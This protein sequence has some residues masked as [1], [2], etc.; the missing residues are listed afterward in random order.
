MKVV[1]ADVHLVDVVNGR[2][3]RRLQSSSNSSPPAQLK[4]SHR[5]TT[6]TTTTP[7][8]PRHPRLSHPRYGD[9]SSLHIGR[10]SSNVETR[11]TSKA[12]VTALQSRRVHSCE[13]DSSPTLTLAAERL[14]QL[15]R[16]R[17][18]RATSRTKPSVVCLPPPPERPTSDK[19]P[20]YN[21]T[22]SFEEVDERLLLLEAFH[23]DRCSNSIPAVGPGQRITANVST[24]SAGSNSSGSV[25]KNVVSAQYRKLWD[26]RATLEESED[27][28]DDCQSES[29]TSAKQLDGVGETTHRTRER[30]TNAAPSFLPLPSELR[31]QTYQ[32]LAVERRLRQPVAASSSGPPRASVDSVEAPETDGDA[33]D[34]SRYDFTT[35]SFESST[36][37]TTTT[38]DNNTD[39]GDGRVRPSSSMT[40]PRLSKLPTAQTRHNTGSQE[41]KGPDVLDVNHA[42]QVPATFIDTPV[43]SSSVRRSYSDVSDFVESQATR[44]EFRATQVPGVAA[45][46]RTA[47]RKR[48][49][50]RMSVQRLAV[51][52]DDVHSSTDQP[53]GDSV[54]SGGLASPGY[55]IPATSAA[56]LDEPAPAARCRP[57]SALRRFLSYQLGSHSAASRN[58]R[59]RHTGSR[60]YRLLTGILFRKFWFEIHI[61]IS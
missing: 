55:M 29:S 12:E 56:S 25:L 5:Y 61:C 39:T 37:T 18:T 50:F 59:C 14:R 24:L 52:H 43:S 8:S 57:S 27:L 31:R 7:C 21:D 22:G 49:D 34:T 20:R 30:P 15:P 33:S 11:S 19:V 38:T 60:D 51:D 23:V 40:S 2:C 3:I 45:S 58:F 54:D 53:S 35:T 42:S 16:M 48:R 44:V 46:L 6:T 13:Y 36:T 26:L 17:P 1:E 32:H 9:I 41:G 10:T 28:S 4:T 47:A